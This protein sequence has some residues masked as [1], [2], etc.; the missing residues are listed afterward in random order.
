MEDVH[1]P[2]TD[3]VRRALSD[4][5]RLRIYEK[6]HGHPQTAR[7]LGEA[8]GR[9][10]N[11]LYYHLRILED[12]GLIAEAGRDVSGRMAER[13]FKSNPLPGPSAPLG[14]GETPDRSLFFGALL[15]ATRAELVDVFVDQAA[16]TDRQM[17]FLRAVLRTTPEGFDELVDGLQRLTNQVRRFQNEPEAKNY[18]LTFALYEPT[19]GSGETEIS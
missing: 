15:E 7:Q 14:H 5:T 8:L 1:P 13:I 4:S 16:G 12:A 3:D 18:R 6:L 17:R 19:D 11:R 2:S 10:A 9:K